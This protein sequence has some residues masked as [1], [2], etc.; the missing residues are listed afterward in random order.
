MNW[1]GG[2]SPSDDLL[3]AW[4]RLQTIPGN[5]KFNVLFPL[6]KVHKT[7]ETSFQ[8]TSLP[9]T[10]IV[11][12]IQTLLPTSVVAPT[13]PDMPFYRVLENV[14][15]AGAD[16][17]PDGNMDLGFAKSHPSSR[18]LMLW[19]PVVLRVRPVVLAGQPFTLNVVLRPNLGMFALTQQKQATDVRFIGARDRM[20]VGNFFTGNCSSA[21]PY[22][23][24][25]D[26]VVTFHA[27]W[28]VTGIRLDTEGENLT[29]VALAIMSQMGNSQ[30][31]FL[32]NKNPLASFNR[33]NG[34]GTMELTDGISVM[35][36]IAK[37]SASGT[38]SIQ[39]TWEEESNNKQ[40]VATYMRDIAISFRTSK[41]PADTAPIRNP[42]ILNRL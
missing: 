20:N 24:G 7:W 2:Y 25:L 29:N 30:F 21:I 39:I 10:K 40:S 18:E 5:V 34:S 14:V 27:P 35:K 9:A 3:T 4:C 11:E 6:T 13:D 42:D 16:K 33:S 1:F 17:A 32:K 41:K 8:G 37:G 15:Q 28:V 19:E 23:D 36:F 31:Q 12:I 26:S 22:C 38:S